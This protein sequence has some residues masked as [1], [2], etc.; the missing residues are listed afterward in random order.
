MSQLDRML[1]GMKEYEPDQNEV[2]EMMDES[3]KERL[4]NSVTGKIEKEKETLETKGGRRKKKH[5]NV[6]QRITKIAAAIALVFITGN[7]V[8]V[9]ATMLH[10]NEKFLSYFGQDELN[11]S[12]I[13]ENYRKVDAT[14]VDKGV[15]I[16]VDQVLGDDHGFYALFSVKG[17]K[18]AERVIEPNFRD[19]N[20]VIEG[21]EDDVPISYNV[22]KIYDDTEDEFSFMLKVNSQNLTGKEI[23]FILMDFGD[24]QSDDFRSIVD[25][26]WDLKWKLSYQN[27]AKKIKVNKQIDL[28]GGKYNW[29]SISI[30]PLSVSVSTTMLEEGV[31]HQSDDEMLDLNDEFYVDFADG[32]RLNKEFMDT[33]DIYMDG[34]NVSMTFHS[35]KDF[36]DV[37]S[38]TF[39][40]VTIPVNP[41]N[42]QPKQLYVNDEMK[43]SMQMSDELYNMVQVSEV[44]SYE[45]EY[46]NTSGQYVSFVG[47]LDDAQMTLFSIYRLKGMI[48]PDE[49]EECAPLMT[50][51]TYKDG[52]TYLIEYGEI[53]SEEQ[54]VFV[55]ILNREIAGIKH[56][57]DI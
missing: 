10:L 6:K 41:D 8:V 30:S 22:L 2:D 15:T 4:L 34:A 23:S 56:F 49:I 26:K 24:G 29:D 28:Y 13:E 21:I 19:Y 51:L 50:Y 40:G 42:R 57:L 39:A 9:G 53:A 31:V 45:D 36:D 32:T 27:N 48:S 3:E 14:S 25:G 16:E 37:V 46:L 18:D 12:E 54:M 33:D 52:Y 1:E 47:E 44:K 38:V 20:V 17:V 5:I 7:V 11:E 43:F 35:I 55:D